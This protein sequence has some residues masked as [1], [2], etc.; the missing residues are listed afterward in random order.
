MNAPAGPPF[1]RPVASADPVYTVSGAR[2]HYR[3]QARGAGNTLERVPVSSNYFADGANFPAHEQRCVLG[4]VAA[5]ASAC[6]KCVDPRDRPP[7]ARAI[8]P[9]LTP[10]HAPLPIPPSPLASPR[11]P[12]ADSLAPGAHVPRAFRPDATS[13]SAASTSATV[14]GRNRAKFFRRPTRQAPDGHR[15]V[16]AEH[17]FVPAPP[18]MPRASAASGGRAAANLASATRPSNDPRGATDSD[19][20]TALP[21][22]RTLGTQSDYRESE[23]QT[24]PYAP[25]YVLPSRPSTRQ[26]ILNAK[27]HTEDD[28]PE[29]LLVQ[30]TRGLPLGRS[31]IDRVERQRRKRAFE[32]SLPPLSD[33]SQLGLRKKL[34]EEWEEAEWAEREREIAQLQEERL[35][36]LKAAIDAREAEAEAT[37][38]ARLRRMRLGALADKT[39]K[40]EAIQHERIR[41]AR[42]LERGRAKDR[43][44][45]LGDDPA[46]FDPN[47]FA[48]RERDVVAAHASYASVVYAP[49]LRDGGVE[50]QTRLGPES[51]F[52][53]S[54]SFADDPTAR[55]P[56]TAR[57][58]DR[59]VGE[60]VPGSALDASV[61]IRDAAGAFFAATGRAK[62]S[63]DD[64]SDASVAAASKKMTIEQRREANRRAELD[65]VARDLESA[66][67]AAGGRRGVGS[68]WPAP[69]DDAFGGGG[70]EKK[71]PLGEEEK[72]KHPT[73]AGSTMPT[74]V[75]SE[76]KPPPARKSAGGA[77]ADR[78]ETPT[79]EP[80]MGGAASAEAFRA[81]VALQ[82]LI[83][84][85]AAAASLESSAARRADLIEELLAGSDDLDG[86]RDSVDAPVSSLALE[87]GAATARVLAAM[88]VADDRER[89]AAFAR[90]HAAIRR[91]EE[92]ALDAAAAR[93]Q[94]THRGRRA[95]L[96]TSLL[97]AER[98]DEE[99]D[100]DHPGPSATLPDLD[101]YDEADRA[102][103]TRIQA[104]ARGRA[105]RRETGYR[106]DRRFLRQVSRAGSSSADYSSRPHSFAS[107]AAFDAA[108]SAVAGASSAD[109]RLVRALQA[110]ARAHASRGAS[111]ASALEEAASLGLVIPAALA[112]AAA[113]LQRHARANVA[114]APTLQA[115]ARAHLAARYSQSARD[116]FRD[117]FLNDSLNDAEREGPGAS[118]TSGAGP[119]RVVARA[120]LGEA[121]DGDHAAAL[122]SLSAEARDA[123]LKIQAAARRFLDEESSLGG[124]APDEPLAPLG[125]SFAAALSEEDRGAVV[126]VQTAARAHLQRPRGDARTQ[127]SWI[128]ASAADGEG[129]VR[130]AAP[131]AAEDLRD[132]SSESPSASVAAAFASSATP[133]ETL[134]SARTMQASA[135]SHVARTG[136]GEASSAAAS[137]TPRLSRRA[138]SRKSR[139]LG[140]APAD[141]SL[142]SSREIPA[143]ASFDAEDEAKV[144]KI[145]AATRGRIAR[146][147]IKTSRGE[148]EGVEAK[149]K[150]ESEEDAEA[151]DRA[152]TRIQAAHRGREARKVVRLERDLA[153]AAEAFPGT[154]AEQEAAAKIQAAH[155]ARG[156]RRRRAAEAEKAATRGG[157]DERDDEK[158]AR[159]AAEAEAA[160]IKMQAARRGTVS[161]RSVAE[162]KARKAEEEAA[163]VKIQAVHRGRAGRREGEARRREAERAAAAA[164]ADAAAGEAN[165]NAAAAEEAN[166]A[167]R[168]AE[169]TASV[170]AEAEAAAVKIQ[171]AHRGAATRRRI[172]ERRRR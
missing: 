57:D 168:D 138:S 71:P 147:A 102:K 14:S 98:R 34:M 125:P 46:A 86:D 88:S 18:A 51:S 119:A 126:A 15:P 117:A 165:A 30:D 83:R 16:P 7:R 124:A 93:I 22:S 150:A 63:A 171:A 172:A 92:A 167:E 170:D 42:K 105:A 137:K 29:V 157:G 122:A 115:S 53:T 87:A 161:R 84:G 153:A 60:T 54:S 152:A 49:R 58:I 114:A 19:D 166:A 134:A 139:G 21:R 17:V 10:S 27:H 12:R 69:L 156:G 65:G 76:N 141:A 32:A 120:A 31:E 133:A 38:E 158:I 5:L 127:A 96:E 24:R 11:R 47:D 108:A 74:G 68:C 2:D 112:E 81:V 75:G 13:G 113:A 160:A 40:F 59:L 91:A 62:T 116:A 135:R 123:V 131:P 8:R 151:L 162:M 94:A 36:I 26:A 39:K 100:V 35:A 169:E 106:R 159:E 101:A 4:P 67:R 145:Q 6:P 82:R 146:R 25:D 9:A 20:P 155:R 61:A 70:S 37:A 121:L 66:K 107:G 72:D 142:S 109:L 48:D 90:T 52:N 33:A 128:Q 89:A 132:A 143:L 140:L 104:Y 41:R 80:A 43:R 77:A 85:R 3:E 164:N 111:L 45:A 1:S 110:S 148:G 55:E 144:V 163:A 23:A 50:F 97:R 136:G 79:L 129:V 95:R 44:D 64:A 28:L 73:V 103:V 149:A 99:G 130:A 154:P 78:P 118:G 56:R